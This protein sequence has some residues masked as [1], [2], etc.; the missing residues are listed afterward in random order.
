MTTDPAVQLSLLSDD[1]FAGIKPKD[2]TLKEQETVIRLAREALRL[3]HQRGTALENPQSTKAYLQFE[4]AERQNEVFAALFLDNKHRIIAF[5]ELFF[6]TVNGT[7]VHPRVVV[8]RALEHN[9]AAVI[10]VHNHPSGAAEPSR[11]DQVITDRLKEVLSVIDIRVLD[12][13]V[14]SVEET[15]SMADQ[16]L[17]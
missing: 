10:F 4:L 7:T 13:I 11:H 5:E 14:V 12:H 1:R 15:V 6:G 3:R 9:A 8:Q 16:G 17:L 2:L